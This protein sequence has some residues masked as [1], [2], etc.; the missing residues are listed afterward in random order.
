[1]P[2]LVFVFSSSSMM[3]FSAVTSGKYISCGLLR[4]QF[5]IISILKDLGVPAPVKWYSISMLNLSSII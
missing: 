1:M 2:V 5:F 3:L 4:S